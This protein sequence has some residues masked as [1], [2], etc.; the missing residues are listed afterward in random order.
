MG[1][2]LCSSD[3]DLHFNVIKE[4]IFAGKSQRQIQKELLNINA[5]ERGGGF[6]AMDILHYYD[7]NGAMK[8]K[9]RENKSK[10][11]NIITEIINQK[12]HLN[13]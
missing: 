9:Y 8:G 6:R 3:I 10:I 1:N 5:P 11:D 7:I 4:Y 13:Q 12:A 2:K